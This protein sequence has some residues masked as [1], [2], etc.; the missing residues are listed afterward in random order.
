MPRIFLDENQLEEL[1]TFDIYED[2]NDIFDE[3]QIDECDFLDVE[4]LE[5]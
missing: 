5:F 2:L 4:N 3:E 1:D